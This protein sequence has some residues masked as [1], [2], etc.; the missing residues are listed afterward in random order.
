MYICR[1]NISRYTP[2]LIQLLQASL[3][4]ISSSLKK[5]KKTKKKKKK[6]DSIVKR[7]N[8]SSVNKIII[9]VLFAFYIG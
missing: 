8:V 2:N 5:K 4:P 3:L 6:N 7:L 1:C 9:T